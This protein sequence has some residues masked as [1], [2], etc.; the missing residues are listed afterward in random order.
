MPSSSTPVALIGRLAVRRAPLADGVE[1]LEAEAERIH[2]RV[3]ARAHRVG[4]ML[5][6][7]LAHRRGLARSCSRRDSCSR[8]GGGGGTGA[9]RMFSSSHLPRMVG[10]VRVGYDVTAST[11]ALPS[12]P[13]R[14]S[15]ASVTRRK[16]LPY[17]PEIP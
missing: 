7:H 16:W 13:Q 11:L 9:A 3:A 6:E 15:S 12:S 1:V 2:A 14:F 10:E 5:L 8:S 17:T 4:A